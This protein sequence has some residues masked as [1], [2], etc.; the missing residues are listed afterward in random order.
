M[1]KAVQQCISLGKFSLFGNDK[2]EN[3]LYKVQGSMPGERQVVE[4]SAGATGCGIQELRNKGL[5]LEIAQINIH[6]LAI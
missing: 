2:L 4:M 5:C 3:K 1:F 6:I